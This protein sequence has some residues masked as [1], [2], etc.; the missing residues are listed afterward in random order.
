MSY[1]AIPMHCNDKPRIRPLLATTLSVAEKFQAH[2]L[3]LSVVPP[4]AVISTETPDG[5]PIIVDE[6]CKLYRE[7]N[8]PMQ[9]AFE[10]A[11]RGRASVSE[12]RDGD[13][14]AF[15][16]AERS[17]A[18]KLSAFCQA[19]WQHVQAERRW[20]CA[21]SISRNSFEEEAS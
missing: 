21:T 15:G 19:V 5:P 16:V 12:W 3:G 17:R 1:K 13:A 6:H 2:L 7:E 9:A 8:P 4:F 14:D 11:T 10:T 20:A 18:A